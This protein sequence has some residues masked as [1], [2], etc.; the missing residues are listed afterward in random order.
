MS[1]QTIL[2]IEDEEDLL[3]L[4]EYHLQKEAEVKGWTK[5]QLQDQ[6]IGWVK[7]EDLCSN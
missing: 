1:K 3:E 2:I 6:K 4:L 5:V 7:N